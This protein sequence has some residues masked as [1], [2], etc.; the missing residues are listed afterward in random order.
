MPKWIFAFIQ[1]VPLS[2]FATYAFWSGTPDESRWEMAFKLASLAAII[3]LAIIVPQ[4]RP[5]NRLILAANLYLLLGG[6]AFLTHQWWFL[7]LY[8]SL[9]E[10]AIFILMLAVGIVAT[11]TSAAGYIGAQGS[12][13]RASLVL[14]FA[15]ALALMFA[16]A[17][18]GDR[19]L[20]AVY[21]IIGLGILQRV[22]LH[23][24]NKTLSGGA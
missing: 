4:R 8:N 16:L 11:L 1:F 20:A 6:L 12:P 19:Y 13:R 7:K 9:Q 24:A 10:A 17:F 15:T 18:R 21:P 14:L 5:T 3:Q 23:R 2:L 22:L